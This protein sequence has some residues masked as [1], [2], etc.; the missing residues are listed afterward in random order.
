MFFNKCFTVLMGAIL[1]QAL[2]CLLALAELATAALIWFI[3]GKL[4]F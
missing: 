1:N 3:A 4:L 2:G